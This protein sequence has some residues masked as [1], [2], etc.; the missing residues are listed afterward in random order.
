M[1]PSLSKRMMC[2]ANM[3]TPGKRIADIGCDHALV[4]IY[5]VSEGISPKVLAMDIGEGPLEAAK[6]NIEKYG[7][8]ESIETRLSD[9]MSEL[10]PGETDGAVI[11]GMGGLTIV[12]IL[13]RGL[14]NISPGYELVLSPQSEIPE[15]RAFLRTH[16][17]KIIDEEM[18]IED[19]KYYNI[20]KAV[21][22]DEEHIDTN[23]LYDTYSQFLIEK[24]S[25]IYLRYLEENLEKMNGIYCRLS[26]H[27]GD[28]V[29]DRMAEIRGEVDDIARILDMMK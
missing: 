16:G 29:I 22:T 3:V 9:G 23:E 27:D 25:P 26:K 24:K 19:D 8:S 5:L 10:K 28:K 6:A 2:L 1:K 17:I 4:S 7:L 12:G 11:A 21:A 20:I 13:E 14:H 15:V 18:I